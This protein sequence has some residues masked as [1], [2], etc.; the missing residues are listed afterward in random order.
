MGVIIRNGLPKIADRFRNISFRRRSSVVVAFAGRSSFPRYRD[1][2][3]TSK[4]WASGRL[5]KWRNAQK[6]PRRELYLRVNRSSSPDEVPIKTRIPGCTRPRSRTIQTEDRPKHGS[7]LRPTGTVSV[8]KAT[9]SLLQL[10][11]LPA[12]SLNNDRTGCMV[13]GLERT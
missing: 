5:A 12:Y 11:P 10:Q 7:P 9:P 13:G 6:I 8:T 1:F 3:T 4:V 2:L